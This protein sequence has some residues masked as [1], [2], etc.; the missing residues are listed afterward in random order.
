MTAKR[1]IAAAKSARSAVVVGSSFIGMEVAASLKK[2]GLEVTVVTPD[3]VPFERT[4]GSEVGE[5][6]QRIHERNGVKFRFKSKVVRIAGG[7][8][9]SS[10]ETLAADLIVLGIGVQPATDWL[11]QQWRNEKGE[12]NVDANLCVP[13]TNS[14]I[15][16][17]GDITR[18]PDRNAES[19]HIEHWRVAEQMGRCAAQ[20]MIGRMS[21]FK[22]VP[23]FWSFQFG[24]GFDY[25]GHAEKW[26]EVKIEGDLETENFTARYNS[27]GKVVV[28]AG[29]GRSQEMSRAVGADAARRAA[30]HRTGMKTYSLHAICFN[31]FAWIARS[32]PGR[33]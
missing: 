32:M 16:A 9:L 14:R 15:F 2:R 7:L 29:S 3:A 26:D 12:V 24:V 22:E 27:N 6:F 1:I 10:G 13:Q 25:V 31:L 21:P 28:M 33:T 4:L 8:Q 30:E 19:V 11:P 18:F 17:A 20:N 5:F 23:Y